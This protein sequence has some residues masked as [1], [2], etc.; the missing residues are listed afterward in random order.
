MKKNIT[1]MILIIL[2]C[3]LF[4]LSSCE[5]QEYDTTYT[6][7]IGKTIDIE[8]EAN[9]S[10]GYSWYWENKDA[11]SSIDTLKREYIEEQ[12]KGKPGKEIWTF[13]GINKGKEKITLLY[14]RASADSIY[15]NKK[16]FIV[17]IK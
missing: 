4:F 10:T 11:V 13:V 6:I 16:E 15:V 17:K 7:S 14:K 5:K 3:N 1:Y 12:G 8:L 9:W 2:I